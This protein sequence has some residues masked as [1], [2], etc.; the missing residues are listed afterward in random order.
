MEMSHN[1][2]RLPLCIKGDVTAFITKGTYAPRNVHL[3]LLK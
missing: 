2:A 1:N 3:P